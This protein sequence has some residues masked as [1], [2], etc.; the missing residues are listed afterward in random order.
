VSAEPAFQVETL[1]V[2]DC[3]ADEE[4]LEEQPTGRPDVVVRKCRAC[5]RRHIEVTVDPL[6]I[7]VRPT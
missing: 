3:C 5:G 6:T 2:V 7:G 4:N 1:A